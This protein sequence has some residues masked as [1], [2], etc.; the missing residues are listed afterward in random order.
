MRFPLR[1]LLMALTLLLA[2]PALPASADP[3]FR[4]SGDRLTFYNNLYVLT[5][6]GHVSI[7]MRNGS[8]IAADSFV[9]D[10]RRRRLI[11]QPRRRHVVF[12][13]A[14]RRARARCLCRRTFLRA[15]AKRGGSAGHLRVSRSEK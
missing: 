1:A 9:I 3:I 8:T 7:D 6:Y 5:G 11:H 10:L 12:H 2:L 14:R 15:G 13:L 4:V